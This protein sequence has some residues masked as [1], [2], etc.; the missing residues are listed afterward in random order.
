MPRGKNKALNKT[1]STPH[2]RGS[3]TGKGKSVPMS[4]QM[5][6]KTV[7]TNEISGDLGSGDSARRHILTDLAKKRVEANDELYSIG[8]RP[9]SNRDISPARSLQSQG[10]VSPEA[11][12]ENMQRRKRQARYNGVRSGIFGTQ[13]PEGNWED[14]TVH[15]QGVD[16]ETSTDGDIS[17][18]EFEVECGNKKHGQKR[19]GLGTHDIPNKWKD[20]TPGRREAAKSRGGGDF[21]F[22]Y[23]SDDIISHGNLA[24]RVAG[25]RSAGII[26]SG[27][28][29][30]IHQDGEVDQHGKLAIQS[31]SAGGLMCRHTDKE[32]NITVENRK[33]ANL[34]G[35]AKYQKKSTSSERIEARNKLQ[36][37]LEEYG[38]DVTGNELEDLILS[39]SKSNSTDIKSNKYQ[40][41]DELGSEL[42]E[43]ELKDLLL[44]EIKN[45]TNPPRTIESRSVENLSLKLNEQGIDEDEGVKSAA[46]SI[47]FS[48]SRYEINWNHPRMRKMKY[49]LE[50]DNIAE[51]TAA[52]KKRHALK[53]C[54]YDKEIRRLEAKIKIQELK[55]TLSAMEAQGITSN[56]DKVD[57]AM[58]P[59]GVD[60]KINPSVKNKPKAVRKHEE[61]A[62]RMCEELRTFM[63]EIRT[64]KGARRTHEDRSDLTKVEENKLTLFPESSAVELGKQAH[65]SSNQ[66]ETRSIENLATA[67]QRQITPKNWIK[68]GQYD[69]TGSL[70]TFLCQFE[71]AA[72]YNG[73]DNIDKVAHLIAN[74]AGNAVQL[75]RDENVAE[76]T[77]D[78]LK[79]KLQ[80]RYGTQGQYLQFRTEMKQRRRYNGESLRSLHQE[81]S[82]LALEAFPGPAS[83]HSQMMIVEAF[84]ESLDDEDLEQKVWGA[85]PKD[86]DEAYRVALKF[87]TYRKSHAMRK[88]SEGRFRHS[89]AQRSYAVMEGDDEERVNQ[90]Y[91]ARNYE[92]DDFRSYRNIGNK[93]GEQSNWNESNSHEGLEY[94]EHMRNL[95]MCEHSLRSLARDPE[96]IMGE[97][98]VTFERSNFGRDHQ[99]DN[100]KHGRNEQRNEYYWSRRRKRSLRCRLCYRCRE[101][102]HI[103]R[104]C[105]L[106]N[107]VIY[108]QSRHDQSGNNLVVNVQPQGNRTVANSQC[109]IVNHLRF[110]RIVAEVNGVQRNCVLDTGCDQSIVPVQLVSN[111]A[112][113][114]TAKKLTA[115][116]G[117][118][119]SLIGETVIHVK[120]GNITIPTFVVVSPE[121]SEMILGIE[122]LTKHNCNWNFESREVEILGYKIPL[123]E[124]IK[125][126]IMTCHR[127]ISEYC[128]MPEVEQVLPLM[129]M[130]NKEPMDSLLVSAATEVTTPNEA[131]LVTVVGVMLNTRENEINKRDINAKKNINVRAHIETCNPQLNRYLEEFRVPGSEC[132]S[133]LTK[134]VQ[135]ELESEN[136]KCVFLFPV[137]S[138]TGEITSVG[139]NGDAELSCSRDTVKP[140]M[141]T[142]NSSASAYPP[143]DVEA[144]MESACLLELR[145][146]LQGGCRKT[147]NAL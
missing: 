98:S 112:L 69:G 79:C 21:G 36:R 31:S 89:N 60:K 105:P 59:D 39:D 146:F 122:W 111:I 131:T 132:A 19:P 35:V 44:K 42:S 86:I 3:P 87:E 77:F 67:C 45:K 106:R 90:N 40:I 76:M 91:D 129:D 115:A 136:D 88:Q 92:P 16:T 128:K 99:F 5:T 103:R 34:G 95:P 97:Q 14:E 147:G 127:T 51:K 15:E 143:R 113:D 107:P 118:E 65:I 57:N 84:I 22:I 81:M 114:T 62:F 11:V 123:I 72:L 75:L 54:D 142:D 135:D 116:N 6:H 46:N 140:P 85:E 83:L 33:L 64:M 130:V 7:E 141:K 1:S 53:N 27:G 56:R 137:E 133:E 66:T 124:N 101:P 63:D 55:N 25:R 138:Y 17:E 68:S 120:I 4:V 109:R 24:A 96:N 37:K 125:Q 93:N 70:T 61:D 29:I 2:K 30:G 23:D 12:I 94:R 121:V 145:G 49:M 26:M 9:E 102:G 139:Y 18:S 108:D 47:D 41:V 38:S 58:E 73:W 74:L 50:V 52:P 144:Q 28:R 10:I 32:L 82:Q 8:N 100:D 43:D 48:E 78:V 80:Q 134:L 126:E 104:N 71:N 117:T 20:S 119:V 110:S 13:V